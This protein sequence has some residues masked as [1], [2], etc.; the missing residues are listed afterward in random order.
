VPLVELAKNPS[1]HKQIVKSIQGKR[2]SRTPDTLNLQY[3]TPT[4]VFGPHIDDEEDYVAPF[5]VTLNVDE[6]ML[7]N[8]M[9]DSIA[10]H[11]I[12]PKL[13]MEKLG[14]ET[15]IPYHDLYYFDARKLK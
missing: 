6:K 15:T 10:S 4:I 8:C 2:S 1:Y 12:M 7:H 13:V 5:Y 11:K 9:L 3:E 14:L